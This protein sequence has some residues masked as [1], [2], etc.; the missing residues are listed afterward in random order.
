[1]QNM[2][3]FFE[4]IRDRMMRGGRNWKN[5]H[6]LKEKQINQESYMRWETKISLLH[7]N[8]SWTS[9]MCLHCRRKEEERTHTYYPPHKGS[10]AFI[11][12][13]RGA[14]SIPGSLCGTSAGTLA[15]CA[16]RIFTGAATAPAKLL[17]QCLT[18]RTCV[19][20]SRVTTK[21]FTSLV[22]LQTL[23]GKVKK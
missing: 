18:L 13:P 22:T 14:L 7:D 23:N 6:N 9:Q 17:K 4:S 2:C 19:G 8:F 3:L 10:Q 11:A 5:L 16:R 20:W 21:L 1:M 15:L 12:T